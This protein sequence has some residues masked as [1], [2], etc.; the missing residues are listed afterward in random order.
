MK[1]M[2]MSVK[3]KPLIHKMP[4]LQCCWDSFLSKYHYVVL[5]CNDYPETSIFGL[6]NSC[7]G[8]K[9]VK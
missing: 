5:P 2:F 9:L 1:E 4:E 3:H 8:S 7:N 6:I